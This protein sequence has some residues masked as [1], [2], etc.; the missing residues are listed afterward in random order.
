MPFDI[1]FDN[2]LQQNG[3]YAATPKPQIQK[4]HRYNCQQIP[5]NVFLSAS[6]TLPL[7]N[8]PYNNAAGGAPHF[9]K[10]MEAWRGKEHHNGL[11]R[12]WESL[13]Q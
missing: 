3:H 7:Y 4:A 13:L 5:L 2:C 1:I 9:A 10:A 6:F 8:N 11:A 12:Q